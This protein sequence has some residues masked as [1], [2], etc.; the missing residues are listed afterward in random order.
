MKDIKK[1]ARTVNVKDAVYIY[2]SIC[3]TAPA[4]KPACAVDR[5]HKV[6]RFL[7]DKPEGEA[8]LG[9]WRC[10]D[11]KKPCSVSRHK[12]EPCKVNSLI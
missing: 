9:G 2:T 7:G 12:K 10:G 11:C 3:C 5:G 8:T 4:S 1:I 6:G